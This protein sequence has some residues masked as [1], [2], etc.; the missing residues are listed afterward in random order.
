MDSTD[1]KIIHLLKQNARITSSEISKK[2][3]LSIQR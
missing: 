1:L 2:I 3:N